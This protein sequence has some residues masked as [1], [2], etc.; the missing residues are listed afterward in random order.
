[1]SGNDERLR[2][3]TSP[4]PIAGKGAPTAARAAVNSSAQP[5]TPSARAKLNEIGSAT[6]AIRDVIARKPR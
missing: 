1:M 2:G 3:L 4:T 5:V 6:K